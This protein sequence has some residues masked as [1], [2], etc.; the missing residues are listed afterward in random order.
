MRWIDRF[1]TALTLTTTLAACACAQDAPDEEQSEPKTLLNRFEIEI[2][3]WSLNGNRN[4]FRQYAVTP[5][6]FV[7]R[8]IEL[9]SPLTEE[10]PYGRF[11][12]S[13]VPGG[14][15][16]AD[17]R[18]IME[19]GRLDVKIHH[20]RSSFYDP[21][22]LLVDTSHDRDTSVEVSYAL[23]PEVGAFYRFDE[24]NKKLNYDPPKERTRTYAKRA[25]GGLSG[26]VLGGQAEVTLS[27]YRYYDQDGGSPDSIHH[28]FDAAYSRDLGPSLSVQG[29]YNRTQIEQRGL[30][31]SEVKRWSI[32]ADW[33]VG[34]YTSLMLDFRNDKVDMPNVAN[35]Y[36]RERFM[37]TA[38]LVHRF[39][40][41][42]LQLAYKHR[43]AERLRGDQTFVDVPKWDTY[44]G[45]LSGHLGGPLRYT[46]RGNWEHMTRGAT[47]VVEDPRALYWD[48]RVM[49]QIKIDGGVDRFQGYATYTFRFDQNDPR[50]VEVRSHNLTVG[51]HYA[52]TDR[53]S[54]YIEFATDTYKVSSPPDELGLTLDAFFPSSTSYA[55]GFDHA[56]SDR[57]SLSVAATHYTTR[58]ANPLLVRDAN[59]RGTEITATYSRVLSPDSSFSIT[60]SPWRYTDKLY[61]QMNYRTT[62]VGLQYSTKF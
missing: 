37:T 43:E 10:T 52:F 54:A 24:R 5:Q 32:G 14:D 38:R 18:L 20:A 59:Y 28:R 46:V 50:D 11:G 62:V 45:R 22:P 2:P 1:A 31:D 36:V 3:G 15:Q 8:K 51:G 61:E 55:V 33:Y 40:G 44:E 27:D 29:A 4:K 39:Q 60:Y 9:F 26:E 41:A 34:P 56:I 13:G 53:T 7:F 21:T 25:T 16:V 23:T 19:Q 47:M 48:D 57:G 17:G 30:S 49:G 35:S 42:A 6:G 12:Y 58:S